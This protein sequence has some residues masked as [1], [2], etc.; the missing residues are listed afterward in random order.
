MLQST[1]CPLYKYTH[2][3]AKY[4][5]NQ[6]D[7]RRSIQELI[8]NSS[9]QLTFSTLAAAVAQH[10]E[11]QMCQSACCDSTNNPSCM[12]SIKMIDTKWHSVDS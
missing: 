1:A 8:G 11:N 4:K 12:F 3:S 9:K 10:F 2:K 5:S 7:L 6:K